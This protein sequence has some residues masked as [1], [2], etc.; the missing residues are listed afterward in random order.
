MQY[1][2][3]MQMSCHISDLNRILLQLNAAPNPIA[4]NQYSIRRFRS[5][6]RPFVLTRYLKFQQMADFVVVVL[7]SIGVVIGLSS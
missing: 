3:L 7:T 6:I 2:K 1:V 5:E 4:L